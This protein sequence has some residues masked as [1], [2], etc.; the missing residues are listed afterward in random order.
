MHPTAACQP[1]HVPNSHVPVALTDIAPPVRQRPWCRHCRCFDRTRR[2]RGMHSR[3]FV[4]HRGGCLRNCAIIYRKQR[5]GFGFAPLRRRTD[6]ENLFSLDC[7]GP[8][9][10]AYSKHGMAYLRCRV[11]CIGP[12][13]HRRSRAV[14]LLLLSATPHATLCTCASKNERLVRVAL[15]RS[16]HG[17]A[18]IRILRNGAR[19]AVEKRPVPAR[20]AQNAR[21]GNEKRCQRQSP[22]RVHGL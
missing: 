5:S 13:E 1:E 6:F 16:S 17:V 12:A 9:T 20:R 19:Y 11:P 14:W 10:A 8:E 4:T 15:F 18:C 7:P 3:R 21:A 2:C 22:W